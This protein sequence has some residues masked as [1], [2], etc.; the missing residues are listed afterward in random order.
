MKLE[1][2]TPETLARKIDFSILPKN[3]TESDILRGCELTRK[4]RFAAFYTSSSFWSP[5]VKRELQGFD[6]IEI[7][8]GL[9]FPFGSATPDAKAF[10]TAEAVRRGCTAVDLVMNV[11]AAKSGRWDVIEEEVRLF[12]D[13]A[14]DAVTKYI[15]DVCFLSEEE[16]QTAAE[17]A[18]RTGV[19]FVK[20]STGQFDGPTLKQVI[21]LLEMCVGTSAKLKV[22]GIKE[23]RPSNAIS[24][25]LAGVERIG[26]RAGVEIVEGLADFKKVFGNTF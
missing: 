7:G 25:L 17:I 14:G 11:G 2:L 5:I 21:M 20:T 23:P 19:N 22:A 15:F 12:V 18:I 10:E 16:L 1:E 26:T 6:D 4:Y 24:L 8:T 9:A 3:T 13:A